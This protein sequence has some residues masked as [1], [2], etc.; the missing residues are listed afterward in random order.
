LDKL[1]D[2]T[3]VVIQKTDKGLS[4]QTVALP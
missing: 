4:L 3:A 2:T 1:N